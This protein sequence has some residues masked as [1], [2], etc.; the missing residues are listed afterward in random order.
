MTQALAA[1][2]ALSLLRPC[3]LGK[4][5][6]TEVLSTI[7][8]ALVQDKGEEPSSSHLKRKQL[9]IFFEL[10]NQEKYACTPPGNEG[11]LKTDIISLRTNKIIFAH[12]PKI[13]FQLAHS[14]VMLLWDFTCP[15]RLIPTSWQ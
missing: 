9:K 1:A 8:H 14:F 4:P 15:H 10:T 5:I 7:S 2:V 6:E 3:K 13:C 12:L 11:C